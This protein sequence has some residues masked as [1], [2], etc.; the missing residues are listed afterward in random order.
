MIE[1]L[2]PSRRVESVEYHAEYDRV[3]GPRGCGWSFPCDAQGRVDPA[4]NPDARANWE[5]CQDP[6]VARFVGVRTYR[7][8][9][10]EPAIGKC[11]C[12][13]RVDLG[14]FTNTCDCGR[15]YNWAGQELAPRDQWDPEDRYAVEGPQNWDPDPE[16][17]VY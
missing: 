12:G 6:T 4:K 13:R 10:T 11:H 9:W 5:R 2:K 8:R 16:I 1:I 3:G 14:G 17:P 7:H 15:E